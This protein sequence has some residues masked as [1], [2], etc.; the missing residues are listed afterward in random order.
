MSFEKTY[1]EIGGIVINEPITAITDLLVA[2]VCFY[3]FFKRTGHVRYEWTHVFFRYYFLF[4]GL[5]TLYGG[6]VGHAFI[7]YFGFEWKLPGWIMSMIGVALIERATIMHAKEYMPY[8]VGRFFSVLNVIEL[9]T[10]L[11]CVVYFMNFSLV[12]AHAAYGLLIVVVAFELVV[13]IK[14][15]QKSSKRILIAVGIGAVAAIVHIGQIIIH[16]WFN[17]L[18]LSHV[19]MAI[20]AYVFYMGAKLIPYEANLEKKEIRDN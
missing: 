3:A 13:F 1:W 12:E 20:S 8:K 18:D 4:L 9:F 16:K 10:L 7:Q 19:L 15:G 6:L 5:S 2:G 14:S 17:H 11:F